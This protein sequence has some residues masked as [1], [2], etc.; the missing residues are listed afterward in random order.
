MTI[1]YLVLSVWKE[2]MVLWIKTFVV[3]LLNHYN[4]YCSQLKLKHLILANLFICSTCICDDD[5]NKYDW[6]CNR[7]P[8]NN[9]WLIYSFITGKAI[10][11]VENSVPCFSSYSVNNMLVLFYPLCID[12]WML[13]K[14]WGEL[15]QSRWKI[16]K[17]QQQKIGVPPGAKLDL[18]LQGA[19]DVPDSNDLFHWCKLD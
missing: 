8:G 6:L 13:D 12:W 4:Q 9:L 19:Q 10:Y 11:W 17:I 2:Q 3:M 14:T 15:C 5:A 7:D 1:Y 18:V 16:Q